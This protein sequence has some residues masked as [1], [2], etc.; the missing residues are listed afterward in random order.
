MSN[1]F[2]LANAIQPAMVGFKR[3]GCC[4]A[5]DLDALPETVAEWKRK[6]YEI[7]MMPKRDAIVLLKSSFCQ[8]N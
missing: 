8:H 5:V 6:G 7:R 4:A 2:E 3:C 1:P